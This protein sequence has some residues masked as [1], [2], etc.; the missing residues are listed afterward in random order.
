[1]TPRNDITI[2]LAGILDAA[3]LAVLQQQVWIATYATEGI[4]DEY[5][6]YVLATFTPDTMRESMLNPDIRTFIAEVDGHVIG[7]VV[8]D[9]QPDAP[10]EGIAGAEI[11]VL[12]VLERFIGQGVGHALLNY[13]LSE[14]KAKG[15]DAVWLTV[16]HENERALRF[17][18]AHHFHDIGHTFFEMDG[19]QYEN[20]IM[21]RAIESPLR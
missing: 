17:Y 16:F 9:L 5:S 8:I 19:N 14:C 18:Q 7:C 11:D 15:Y 4:R 2:R 3:N 1:M 20:R 10:I 6:T 21:L 13:A 12:Y